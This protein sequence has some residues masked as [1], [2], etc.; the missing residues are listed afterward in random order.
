MKQLVDVIKFR[1]D[2]YSFVKDGITWYVSADVTYRV[3]ADA[4]TYNHN[5]CVDH[6]SPDEFDCDVEFDFYENL[7][8]AN[9]NDDVHEMTDVEIEDY[10][11]YLEEECK[12]H[13]LWR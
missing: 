4:Y 10:K 8:C 7:E 6:D 12:A 1:D 2:E 5:C 9:E 11:N 13:Y 3:T